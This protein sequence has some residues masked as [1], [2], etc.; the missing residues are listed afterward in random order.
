[1]L[2]TITFLVFFTSFLV[3]CSSSTYLF[4]ARV[5]HHPV[6]SRTN[7]IW[8]VLKWPALVG[9][10]LQPIDAFFLM[11]FIDSFEWFCFITFLSFW[12]LFRNQGDDD[13]WKKTRQKVLEKVQRVAARLEVIPA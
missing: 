6:N 11:G 9:V 1:M 4:V 12:L 8:I 7:T 13:E 10:I 2:L 5:H 3:W